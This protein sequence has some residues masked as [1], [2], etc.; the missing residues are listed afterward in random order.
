[1]LLLSDA[2]IVRCYYYQI[3]QMLLLSDATLFSLLL[4]FTIFYM[5]AVAQPMIII[6]AIHYNPLINIAN[7]L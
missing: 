4:L 7:P 2:T 1:M 3:H 6:A 5:G